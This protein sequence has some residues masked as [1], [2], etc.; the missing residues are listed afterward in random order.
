MDLKREFAS[1]EHETDSESSERGIRK[2][3]RI[4]GSDQTVATKACTRCQLVMP[5]SKFYVKSATKTGYSSRCKKCHQL[6]LKNP[7]LKVVPRKIE[8]NVAECTKCHDMLPLTDFDV[9][10]DR[11]SGRKSSCKKCHKKNSTKRKL[12][13]KGTLRTSTPETLECQ[14]CHKQLPNQMFTDNAYRKSGRASLCKMCASAKSI[15]YQNSGKGFELNL[16][17][18]CISQ[19]IIKGRVTK[20]ETGYKQSDG[21]VVDVVDIQWLQLQKPFICYISGRVVHATRG[22]QCQMTLDRI[23]DSLPHTKTNTKVA[24]L[25]LNVA[26]KWTRYKFM[27]AMEHDDGDMPEVRLQNMRAVVKKKYKH[28]FNRDTQERQCVHCSTWKQ[29]IDFVKDK[30]KG[31]SVCRVQRR[32]Q[33]RNKLQTCLLILLARA[34]GSARLWTRK[35]CTLTK[36]QMF[37]MYNKQ[38]GLCAVSGMRMQTGKGDWNVSLERNNPRLGYSQHNCSLICAEFNVC[39]TTVRMEEGKSSSVA[40]TKAKYKLWRKDYHDA[41]NTL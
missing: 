32:Q 29:D 14:C 17:R 36:Q 13:I 23:N 9:Q 10:G 6:V 41:K 38:R 27:H 26:S 33:S 28:N 16:L 37:A 22:V 2:K 5:V 39:D 30:S 25:E 20:T 18:N 21:S 4:D 8:G 35:K 3:A 31:C 34:N 12:F 11:K 1:I 40:W 24:A 7:E 15:T 19:D